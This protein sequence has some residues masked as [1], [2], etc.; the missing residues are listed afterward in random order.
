VLKW[1]HDCGQG[2]VRQVQA[3]STPPT[4]KLHPHTL[5]LCTQD[6]VAAE[7]NEPVGDN[8][9]SGGGGA[10]GAAADGNKK[11]KRKAQHQVGQHELIG[12][13]PCT[14]YQ[15]SKQPHK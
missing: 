8:N 15:R 6:G 13:H 9:V 3:S 10:A 14:K 4:S 2:S 7:G 5:L 12:T 11:K 1:C